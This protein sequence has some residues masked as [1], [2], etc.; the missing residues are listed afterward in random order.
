MIQ[1]KNIFKG[2]G[3]KRDI[4]KV[5]YRERSR[6]LVSEA[7]N[8]ESGLLDTVLSAHGDVVFLVM[9]SG[10]LEVRFFVLCTSDGLIC[11]GQP[12]VNLV[13]DDVVEWLMNDVVFIHIC[14]LLYYFG[15]MLVTQSFKFCIIMQKG[16]YKKRSRRDSNSDSWI[17]SPKC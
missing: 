7:L 1:S 5:K 9:F 4:D 15:S 17:Q 16:C 8:I 2:Y 12:F 14:F 6:L 3:K 13:E 10:I 11:Q